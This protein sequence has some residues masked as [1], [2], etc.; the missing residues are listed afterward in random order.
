MILSHMAQA[1]SCFN[2]SPYRAIRINLKAKSTT[3]EQIHI[4]KSILYP[5]FQ[6][7]GKEI[8]IRRETISA[9]VARLDK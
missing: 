2:M 5:N 3:C 1:L 6:I 4:P 7:S 9:K 8:C